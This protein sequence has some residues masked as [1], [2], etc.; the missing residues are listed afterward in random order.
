MYATR[1]SVLEDNLMGDVLR[2]SGSDL[3]TSMSTNEG[4][5]GSLKSD[6]ELVY[7][8]DCIARGGCLYRK[9]RLWEIQSGKRILSEC[10]TR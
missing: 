5:S 7:H 6:Y 8:N 2:V 1:L 9:K 10:L 3:L 4:V